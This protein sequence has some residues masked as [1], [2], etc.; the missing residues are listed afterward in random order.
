MI[1]FY[2]LSIYVATTE[3]LKEKTEIIANQGRAVLMSY[4]YSGL[5][6]TWSS[7]TGTFSEVEVLQMG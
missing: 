2:Y 4:T 5:G 6:R 3:G 1:Q 7:G